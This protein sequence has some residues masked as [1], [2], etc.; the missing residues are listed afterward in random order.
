LI[1][2]IHP[3]PDRNSSL[4]VQTILDGS[5]NT[6][7]FSSVSFN[8]FGPTP[9]FVYYQTPT[10][11]NSGNHNITFIVQEVH[12]AA[13]ASID[14]LTYKPSF[15]TLRDKPIFSNTPV[16]TNNTGQSTETSDGG[17]IP[18]SP[19]PSTDNKAPNIGSIVGG[20]VGGVVLCAILVLCFWMWS[21]NRSRK[22]RQ[23][24]ATELPA[25]RINGE[26]PSSRFKTLR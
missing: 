5:I 16:D 4:V 23:E 26:E 9:H 20:A 17:T 21:R 11:L 10:E 14:Y 8:D 1:A 15:S 6:Q 3:I 22:D 13:T 7:S 24:A 2:G 18:G 19:T 25:S 12:G